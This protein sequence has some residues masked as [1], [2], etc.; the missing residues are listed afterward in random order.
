MYERELEAEERDEEE[1]EEEEGEEGEDR[2]EGTLNAP[3]AEKL[4]SLPMKDDW[5]ND[6]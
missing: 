1:D 5:L 2:D 3:K 6:C 4:T